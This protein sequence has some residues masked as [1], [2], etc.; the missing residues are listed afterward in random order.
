[1]VTEQIERAADIYH[2]WQSEGTD[3]T[4]YEV[5]ELYRSV[6]IEEIEGKGWTFTPSK[7]IEFIDHDLDIDYE[8]EMA[9]IQQE[10]KE[11]MQREKE[12]QKMLEEAFN[13]IGYGI[14]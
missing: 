10:M 1:M 14:E 9:R 8:K 3:G 12:S 4:N 7:Y 2:T 5:P 11:L 13:G 6:G